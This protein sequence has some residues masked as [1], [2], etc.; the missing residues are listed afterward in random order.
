LSSSTRGEGEKSMAGQAIPPAKL[1]RV[2]AV[3]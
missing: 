1:G 3:V 2:R